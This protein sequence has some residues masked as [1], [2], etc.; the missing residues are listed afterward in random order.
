MRGKPNGLPRIL[1]FI[2]YAFDGIA[3]QECLI[4]RLCR[5]GYFTNFTSRMKSV[6]APNEPALTVWVHTSTN[7]F[8]DAK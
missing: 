3:M 8:S 7:M 1:L 6:P 5:H 2:A 4:L